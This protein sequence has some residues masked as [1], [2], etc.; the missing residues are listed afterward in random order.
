MD[1]KDV[2]GLDA[3][4][5]LVAAGSRKLTNTVILTELPAAQL[6][7]SD[8]LS[9]IYAL[10]PMLIVAIDRNNPIGTGG[11]A[12]RLIDPEN[13]PVTTA[14]VNTVSVQP[15]PSYGTCSRRRPNL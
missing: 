8:F 15:T 5:A 13:R 14:P 2:A 11:G 3:L 7:R 4:D 6:A 9:K 1:F 12:S 10:K